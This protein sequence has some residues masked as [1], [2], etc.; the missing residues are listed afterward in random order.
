MVSATEKVFFMA[1]FMNFMVYRMELA[2]W[3][4]ELVGWLIKFSA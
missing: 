3:G 1:L 2:V 4:I